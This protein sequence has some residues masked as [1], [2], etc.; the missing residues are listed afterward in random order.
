MG[1][2]QQRYTPQSLDMYQI[3]AAG[4]FFPAMHI[5]QVVKLSTSD[6]FLQSRSHIILVLYLPCTWAPYCLAVLQMFLPFQPYLTLSRI[7]YKKRDQE[8]CKKTSG[9]VIF[10][11][12]FGISW[13]SG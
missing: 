12:Y 8:Q 9:F 7:A 4:V 5:T 10:C 6:S 13:L 1:V 2:A 3:T 11:I